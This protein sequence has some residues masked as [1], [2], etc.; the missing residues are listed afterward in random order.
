ML[1]NRLTG[2]TGKQDLMIVSGSQKGEEET[3]KNLTQSGSLLFYPSASGK[4][5]YR[6][7]HE[8]LGIIRKFFPS[9]DSDQ[10]RKSP[11]CGLRWNLNPKKVTPWLHKIGQKSGWT[12]LS[13][14]SQRGSQR[15]RSPR[16][17]VKKGVRIRSKCVGNLRRPYGVYVGAVLSP[18]PGLIR[19]PPQPTTCVVGFI[20]APLRGFGEAILLRFAQPVSYDTDSYGTGS[21]I[22]HTT[23]P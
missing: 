9:I 3:F 14:F 23:Q 19:L 6:A 8:E 12:H 2:L 4:R 20:L 18:R 7:H 21:A 15:V 5:V 22:F 17:S 13:G 11:I 1:Q 16:S 10:R